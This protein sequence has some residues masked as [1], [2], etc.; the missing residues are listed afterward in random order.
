MSDK[1]KTEAYFNESYLNIPGQSD[2][3]KWMNAA[4][5]ITHLK[6]AGMSFDNALRQ[7]TESW[8]DIEAYDFKNWYSYYLKGDHLRYKQAQIW[9]KPTSVLNQA[10]NTDKF[11][12]DDFL[13]E[14]KQPDM[15]VIPTIDDSI[16]IKDIQS[17]VLA[18]LNAAEKLLSSHDGIQFA[19]NQLDELLQSIHSLKRQ[20]LSLTKKSKAT[21]LYED[22]IIREGNR[23]HFSGFIKQAEYLYKL[24]GEVAQTIPPTPE[25][26]VPVSQ[27]PTSNPDSSGASSNP[28]IEEDGGD[29][30]GEVAIEVSDQA[31]PPPTQ[32]VGNPGQLPLGNPDVGNMAPLDTLSPGM[33]GF[34][35]NIEP[36]LKDKKEELDII[37]VDDVNDDINNMD[38]IVIEAQVQEVTQADPIGVND[39]GLEITDN[40]LS[41]FDAQMTNLLANVTVQDII[42]KLE[43]LAKVF[44]IREIPR[45]L[46]LIDMMLDALNMSPL[47]PSLSEA[48]NKAL[49]SNNYISTRIE[50]ILAK[51]RGT[52]DTNKIDLLNKNITTPKDPQA[53]NIKNKLEQEDIKNKERKEFKKRLENESLDQ[54]AKQ[55]VA[56]Q[57]PEIEIQEDLNT[58]E[59]ISPTVVQPPTTGQPSAVQSK[60]VA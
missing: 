39:E 42:Q 58:P 29:G 60:P 38:D 2:L 17:K 26:T 41:A 32:N 37:D 51:L 5:E 45:Q 52:L 18:R 7:T 46:S 30:D 25:Q 54:A 48:T 15:P 53:I 8:A 16:I 9:F 3:T 43:D 10:S 36:K 33:K 20:V 59:N 56:M 34:L 19:G 44:K 6:N 11:N 49:E 28:P 14:P 47:F 31:P 22:L 4:K 40:D 23:L 21:K 12:A 50:E 35:A 24:A 57:E 1:F 13:S 27:A 55:Q